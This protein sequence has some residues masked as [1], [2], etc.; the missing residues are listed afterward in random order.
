MEES[1]FSDNKKVSLFSPDKEKFDTPN[2]LSV[3]INDKK[4][5]YEWVESELENY[6]G[7]KTYLNADD[8]NKGFNK[9]EISY[10]AKGGSKR[11]HNANVYK[12]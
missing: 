6:K 11:L 9:I 4:T 5:N 8:F 1:T 3:I 12:P 10:V 2:D 7:I